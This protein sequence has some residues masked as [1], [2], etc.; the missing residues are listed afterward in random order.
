[1]EPHAQVLDPPNRTVAPPSQGPPRKPVPHGKTAEQRKEA[2]ALQIQTVEA[3]GFHIESQS[4]FRAVAVRGKPVNHVRHGIISVVTLGAWL[5]PWL[6]L[7]VA[8]G[9]TRALISV[10][11]LGNAPVQTL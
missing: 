3:Q 1:M 7:A 11:E 9:E 10:D 8:G 5:I 6:I 2:L 4:D